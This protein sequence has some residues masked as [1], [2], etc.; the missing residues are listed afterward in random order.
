MGSIN[1]EADFLVSDGELQ[2]HS[3]LTRINE[4]YSLCYTK[5]IEE[6]NHISPRKATN[7]S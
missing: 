3:T 7:F 2:P 1:S 4:Y 5:E 6:F